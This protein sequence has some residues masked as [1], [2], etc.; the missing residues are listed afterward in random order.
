MIEHFRAKFILTC[1]YIFV[2]QKKKLNNL[3]KAIIGRYLF[4]LFFWFDSSGLRP[5]K[6]SLL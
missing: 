4:F 1:S 5:G 3:N 6:R 2:G